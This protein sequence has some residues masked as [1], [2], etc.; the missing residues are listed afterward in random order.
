M[1]QRPQSGTLKERR[2]YNS[3]RVTLIY[4]VFTL[5]VLAFAITGTVVLILHALFDILYVIAG[6][7]IV[8]LLILFLLCA[9]GPVR[10][11]FDSLLRNRKLLWEGDPGDSRGK[12]VLSDK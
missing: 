1:K 10:L 2:R 4:F 11:A 3:L 8:L 12:R 9:E 7:P 5:M 6:T